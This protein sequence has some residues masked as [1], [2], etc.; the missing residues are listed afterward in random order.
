MDGLPQNRGSP[1]ALK[2]QATRFG[3]NGN[4]GG[5]SGNP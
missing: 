2:E 5:A 3:C 4:G 1:M